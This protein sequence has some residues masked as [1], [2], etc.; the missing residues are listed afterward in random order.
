MCFLNIPFILGY[1]FI[2]IFFFSS[3]LRY[4]CLFLPS[5][6]LFLQ[7][8]LYSCWW[9]LIFWLVE[10]ILL[11]FLN[12]HLYWKQL[13]HLVEIYFKWILYYDQW[14]RISFL[15]GRIFF[16]SYLFQT[17]IAIRGRPIF[18]KISFLLVEPVFFNFSRHWFKW[19]QSF[20]PLKS[21]FSTSFILASGN[22]FCLVTNILL[23]FRTLFF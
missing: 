8:I 4:S 18:T 15:I 1:S 17:I 9:K 11:Q 20:S 10:T 23:L 14:Q 3:S 19:K 2:L 16:H 6:N 7:H 5:V 13:F 12:Y 22:G 21:H